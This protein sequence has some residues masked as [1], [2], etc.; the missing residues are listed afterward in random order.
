LGLSGIPWLRGIRAE[1]LCYHARARAGIARSGQ[2]VGRRP[3]LNFAPRALIAL[4]RLPV[5]VA[6]GDAGV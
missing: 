3:G 4:R 2:F 6:P 1:R 5:G